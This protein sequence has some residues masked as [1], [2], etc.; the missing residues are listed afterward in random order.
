MFEALPKHKKP[1]G[2]PN[3]TTEPGS[4]G[5][6]PG[7]WLRRVV[8]RLATNFG[9]DLLISLGLAVAL[10]AILRWGGDVAEWSG[11]GQFYTVIGTTFAV[12]FGSYILRK[13]EDYPGAR[14]GA[15]VLPSFIVTYLILLAI[16]V[17]LR[18][19]YNR[20]LLPTSFA[21]AVLWAYI[22]QKLRQ[23][24]GV[25]YAIVPGGEVRNLPNVRNVSWANL[26]KPVLNGDGFA[27]V[28]ADLKVEKSEEW[29]RFLTD[30]AVAG[31]PV[32]DARQIAEAL[33]G[34]VSI[35][36]LSENTLGSINP[37]RI[38]TQVRFFGDWIAALLAL[39]I[40]I[41]PLAVIALII[42]ATSPGP[43]LF[44]QPRV[45]FRGRTF[46]IYKFRSMVVPSDKFDNEREQAKTRNDDGR[47][48]KIGKFMR[49]ARIDELPQILNILRGE[50]SWIGPRPE[51]VPLSKWYENKLPFYRYRHIVRP[52]I[53]GWAQVNQGHVVEDDQVL[54]KLHYDFYYIKNYS[55]WLD[56]MI[57]FRTVVTVVNGLGAK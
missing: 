26:D 27:G 11:P 38:Y 2:G 50:M 55:P 3:K 54:D 43:A 23:A 46:Q 4:G 5:N 20:F 18:L 48:T 6:G 31:T 49:R 37:N 36:H 21:L 8:E 1:T 24:G 15:Y 33:T 35:R 56:I 39:I 34:R 13:I 12:A 52:G 10:P 14:A 29:Q 25:N 9:S 40:L 32:Y 42:R 44:V 41:A 28:V 51:A 57:V 7:G 47:I 16:F 30:Q 53:T 17:F 19:E 22:A 45:G